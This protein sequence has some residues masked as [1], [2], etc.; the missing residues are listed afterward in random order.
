MSRE[1]G[2]EVVKVDLQ[3]ERVVG[4][5]RCTPVGLTGSFGGIKYTITNVTSTDGEA[6]IFYL[7]ESQFKC[8]FL[9]DSRTGFIGL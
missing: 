6:R 5:V 8:V 1:M 7:K 2:T 9:W 3:L 4:A